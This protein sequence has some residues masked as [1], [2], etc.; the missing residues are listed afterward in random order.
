MSV[1]SF[2]IPA[3]GFIGSL[4]WSGVNALIYYAPLLMQTLG[5]NP[6]GDGILIAAGFVSIAQFIAV[7]PALLL[8]D[9]VGESSGCL[10]V[11]FLK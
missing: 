3:I 6:D 7:T 10:L 11:E 1:S 4:E 5:L 8:I 9:R 2:F